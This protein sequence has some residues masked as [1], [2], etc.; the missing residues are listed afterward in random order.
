L[1]LKRI[2][3]FYRARSGVSYLHI[4]NSI[5]EFLDFVIEFYQKVN[6]FLLI[7]KRTLKF[8]IG[9]LRSIDRGRFCSSL[10]PFHPRKRVRSQTIL[11]ET[12][13]HISE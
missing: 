10:H 4:L 8:L 9:R 12:Q 6:T 2:T 11:S 5:F 3:L 13:N 7:E 1:I